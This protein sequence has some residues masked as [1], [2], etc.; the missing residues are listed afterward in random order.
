MSLQDLPEN[1]HTEV[2]IQRRKGQSA[3]RPFDDVPPRQQ[4]GFLMP[5]KSLAGPGCLLRRFFL[6]V[7]K[8][9][10][11][12]GDAT[13]RMLPYQLGK[14]LFGVIALQQVGYLDGPGGFLQLRSGSSHLDASD[15][16][17]AHD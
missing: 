17:S 3:R 6:S 9:R 8:L 1:L 10:E 15:H 4:G 16:V 5:A 2:L 12:A 11:H 14:G 7:Q 13:G